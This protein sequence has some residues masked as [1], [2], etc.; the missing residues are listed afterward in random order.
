MDGVHRFCQV[1]GGRL[2]PGYIFLSSKHPS[3]MQ[4][5][6]LVIN[7]DLEALADVRQWFAKEGWEV[8]TASDWDMGATLAGKLYIDYVLIDSRN[9]KFSNRSKTHDH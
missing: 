9:E 7:S 5:K 2:C 1:N 8:V 3:D 4:K 6:I